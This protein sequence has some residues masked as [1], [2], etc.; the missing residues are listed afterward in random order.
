MNVGRAS[1]VGTLVVDGGTLDFSGQQTG[2]TLSGAF[3]SIG[4]RGGTGVATVTNGSQVNFS[5]LGT[6]GAS[7]N[8]G[9]TSNNPLGNGTL[10]VSGGSHVNLTAG[11]GLATFSVG[12]DGTGFAT[13]KEGSSI[14]VG[15]GST[16]I[17]R[18]AGSNG[19]LRLETGSTLNAGYVGIGRTQ[20]GDGGSGKLI[21]SNSTLTA[22]TIEVGTAGLLGGNG[23]TINGDVTLHGILSP[24]ESLGRI[25]VNGKFNT[26]SGELVLEV[27]S[28]GNGGF[29]TDHLIL[30]RGSAFGFDG[31]LVTFDFLAGADPNAFAATGGFD[32]DTFLQSLD[33][34]TGAITGLS[35]AF[36]PGQ[37]WSSVL[38]T[39]TFSA[40]SDGYT[41][42]DFKVAADGSVTFDAVPV[43]EPSTWA[44]MFI[45]LAAVS[46]LARRR[47]ARG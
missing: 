16:Y 21:V 42:S 39:A 14:N 1:G 31:V 4:N 28:N 15:D 37:T 3:L 33:A 47:A 7:L 35:D 11:P 19:T 44:L 25:V 22:T 2:S 26:G 45:G 34:S 27:G 12:R 36:A 17:G 32:M 9:G 18:L 41:L 5:N 24:G 43:P 46:S 23:G 8:L 6:A 20:D 13:F 38:A 40:S 30:T 29:D 10:T